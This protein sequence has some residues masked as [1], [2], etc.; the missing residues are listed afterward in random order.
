MGVLF[1]STLEEESPDVKAFHSAE[2]W[3]S[4]LEKIKESP[5]LINKNQVVIYFTASWCGPCKFITPVFNH[6]AAEFANADFVKIDVD[7]L[8]GVA[9]EFKVEAMPTFVLWKEGKEVERVVGA[10]KDELQNKIKK[11]YQL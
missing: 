5:K 7:E 11:H 8:S 4:Y 1:S 6:M 10:N 2:R 9:K 3:E